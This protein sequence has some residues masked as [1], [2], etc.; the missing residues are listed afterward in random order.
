MSGWQEAQLPVTPN[1]SRISITDRHPFSMASTMLRFST[2]KQLQVISDIKVAAISET[3]V[4][5][6]AVLAIL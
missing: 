5:T 2:L 3:G 4:R 6:T 1:K